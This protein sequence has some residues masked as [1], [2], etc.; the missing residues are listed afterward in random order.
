MIIIRRAW[1]KDLPELTG[2]LMEL[3]SIEK[4]FRFDSRKQRMGLLLLLKRR[5]EAVIIVAT[6]KGSLTGMAT[7]QL[8][9]STAAGAYSVL[10]E[11]V[12]V[13]PEFR[14]MGIGKKLLERIESWGVSKGAKRMQLVADKNNI[15]AAGFYM[16]N[17][18][19]ESSMIGFYKTI[20]G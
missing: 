9:V 1:K 8:V 19:S 6:E 2:L 18:W 7:G 20:S 10:V 5:T 14:K 12:V 4:D 3:F 13:R 17:G 11:D 16:K 15:T